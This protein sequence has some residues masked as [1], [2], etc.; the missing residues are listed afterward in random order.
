MK[1]LVELAAL[2]AKLGTIGFGG[3]AAHMAMMDR[4]I[5]QRRAWL[6]R[7]QFLDLL[8]VTHLIPGPNSTEMAIHVGYRRGGFAGLVVAGIAFI[9]PAVLITYVFAWIYT[10]YGSLPQVQ[11]LLRG[12]NPCVLAIILVALRDFGS[13][14]MKSWPLWVVGVGVAAAAVA[15]Y[16]AVLTLLAGTLLGAV[17]LC[18]SSGRKAARQEQPTSA[19]CL[20]PLAGWPLTSS[21]AGATP[22]AS[23]GAAAGAGSAA[24]GLWPV[25]LIFLKVGA[26]LYGG[27]YVLIAYLEG[28]LVRHFGWLTE[29]QLLDAIAVG[30]FTPG[31][32]LST[33]TFVGYLLAGT[34]G[35]AV[36]TAGVFLPS[37]LFVVAVNPLVPRLRASRRAGLFLD[38]VNA[39]SVGLMAGVTLVLARSTLVDRPSWLLFAA[40]TLVALL[41]K[42][43]PA[44][45][46][47]GGAVAG[48]VLYGLP[49]AAAPP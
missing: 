30:Q 10:A 5:V 33:A 11:P 20:L 43:T 49:V 24:V 9:L 1:P 27:G 45:L 48:W 38:A 17:L 46:V 7:E 15:G 4:E 44:W 23:A 25:F 32:I 29:K 35:A 6:S 12:I 21:L 8:G 40:A 36:A 19:G 16:D 37:F 34:A 2:F 28:D 18:W 42:P 14:A 31:P 3:P 39:A 47:L 13:A 41:W 26:V 22:A